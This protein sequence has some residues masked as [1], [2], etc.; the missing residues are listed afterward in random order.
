MNFK[1][2]ITVY[3]RSGSAQT[4]RRDL[5]GLQARLSA[6]ERGGD[7]IVGNGINQAD[8]KRFLRG[9]TFRRHKHLQ[10]S[11][12]TDQARKTLR[13]SPTCHQP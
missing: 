12:F 4:A 13:A 1:Q 3:Q 11:T 8:P 9:Y 5:L 2:Q 10:R 6:I 7:R